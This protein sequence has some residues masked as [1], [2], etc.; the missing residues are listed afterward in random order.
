MLQTMSGLQIKMMA[1]AHVEECIFVKENFIK[2]LPLG[3]TIIAY[4][5]TDTPQI[6]ID[7][8]CM[9]STKVQI[10]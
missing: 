10:C 9:I 4:N 8:K 1:L 7:L 6:K 5:R 2:K 3:Q